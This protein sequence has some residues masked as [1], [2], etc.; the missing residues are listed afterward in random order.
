MNI[1]PCDFSLWG[2]FKSKQGVLPRILYDG[3]QYPPGGWAAAASN[4]TQ[5]AEFKARGCLL[6]YGGHFESM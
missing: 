1:K 4:D 6:A 5:S 2:Y 3:G